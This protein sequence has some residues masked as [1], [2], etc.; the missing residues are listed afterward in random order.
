MAKAEYVVPYLGQY[1]HRVAISNQCL[2]NISDT[3]VTLI[4]KDY[5]DKAI[6]KP[7]ILE[8]HEFLRRFC[9]HILPRRFVKI[10]RYGI[11]NHTTKGNLELQFKPEEKPEIVVAESKPEKETAQERLKRLTGF[12]I[13]H[14]PACKK[15]K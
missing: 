15:A 13:Y 6:K 9:M 2:L 4:A 10:R 5:R 8:G 11:Y 12:D 14:C 3:H 7:A 1:R